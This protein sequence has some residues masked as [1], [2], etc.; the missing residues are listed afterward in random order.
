V[1]NGCHEEPLFILSR[2][3]QLNDLVAFKRAF[4]TQLLFVA[5]IFG[6]FSVGGVVALLVSERR[7][8]LR[9]FLFGS[10]CLA[11]LAFIVAATLDAILLPAMGRTPPART[12]AEA[13]ALLGLSEVAIW[14]VIV[15][16]ALL[17]ISIGAFGFAFSRRLGWMI[18]FVSAL[19]IAG[20]IVSAFHL[21]R[22]LG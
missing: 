5:S 18:A 10:L 8:R 11:S 2:L 15:G 21:T 14:N 16:A 20:I 12:P 17:L 1:S 13:H 22:V 19:A 6:A 9:G 4:L 3:E 7:D